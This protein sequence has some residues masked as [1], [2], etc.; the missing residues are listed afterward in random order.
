[1]VKARKADILNVTSITS[2][3]HVNLCISWVNFLGI[4]HFFID[5][6]GKLKYLGVNLV[7]ANTLE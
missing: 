5:F 6:E 2:S 7:N 3:A 4:G 1:M